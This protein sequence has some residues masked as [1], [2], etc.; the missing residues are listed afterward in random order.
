MGMVVI[1]VV[2]LTHTGLAGFGENC[3]ENNIDFV[4]VCGE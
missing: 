1:P 4:V 3:A 2:G